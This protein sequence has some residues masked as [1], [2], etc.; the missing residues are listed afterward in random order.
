MME[1]KNY[2]S[3]SVNLVCVKNVDGTITIIYD[4]D[5]KFIIYQHHYERLCNIKKREA[6]KKMLASQT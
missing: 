3:E 4:N 2:F 5:R 6:K 1:K